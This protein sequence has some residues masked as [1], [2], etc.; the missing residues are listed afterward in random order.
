MPDTSFVQRREVW[1]SEKIGRVRFMWATGVIVLVISLAVA[2]LR[3]YRLSELPQGI[4]SGEA[5]NAMDALGVLKGD[6]AVFFAEKVEGREGMVVYAMAL[7]IALLGRT[8]LALHLPSA[9]ASAGTVFFVFWL[10]L[11]LFGKDAVGR[12]AAPW[13]GLLIGGIGAGLL[14]VSLGQT[15]IG[16]TAYRPPF[17]PLFL[18]PCILFL[19]EGWTLRSRLRVVLAGVCAGLLPYT[20]IPARFTPI[21]FL[22]FGLSLVLSFKRSE[23]GVMGVLPSVSTSRVRAELRLAGTFVGV[24]VIV[25]APILLYF[26]L[27]PE[28]FDSRTGRL[29]VFEPAFSPRGPLYAFLSNSWYH[30]LAFGIRGDPFWR[31]NFAEQPMLNLWEAFFFWL[32]VGIAVRHWQR[33][34]YRLLLLWLV[35]LIAPALLSTDRSVGFEGP[36]TLRMIGAVPA[37]YLLIGLGIWETLN[38]FSTRFRVLGLGENFSHPGS[39]KR[40]AIVASAIVGVLV[41]AQGTVT[42]RTYFRDWAAAPEVFAAYHQEWTDLARVLNEQARTA[43]EVYL[44]PYNDA[45]RPFGFDYLYQGAAPAHVVVATTAH[46]LAQ[47]IESTLAAREVNSTVHYVDWN[48]N[49]ILIENGD[50]H[51]SGVLNKYGRYLGTV[52]YQSFQIHSYADINLNP[53]WTLYDLL[54]PLTVHY[55]GGISLLGIALGQGTKQLSTLRTPKLGENRSLWLALQWQVAPELDIDYSASL[56]LYDDSGAAVFQEDVVLKNAQPA[57]TSHWSAGE[58]VDTFFYL[59]LPAELVPSEYELRLLVYDFETLKP[60][61]ELGVWEPEKAL[62]RLRLDGGE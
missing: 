57:P 3:F 41:L 22:L 54:E 60:T 28:N 1:G 31:H 48:D 4:N 18:V 30:L 24:S 7:F 45:D 47:K 8:E 56:R 19:W 35:V 50:E 27:N 43:D 32:G 52:Q 12:W 13:R 10:G 34:A 59:N 58:Q 51:L 25:A 62:A 16:R 11:V 53:L 14:A 37:V 6:H 46:N 2:L 29:S 9:L 23:G 61:V 39:G 21:L 38:L 42:F 26:A 49:Y 44:L 55:D 15:I 20:Y 33:P 5:A 40:P 36:N 17:L